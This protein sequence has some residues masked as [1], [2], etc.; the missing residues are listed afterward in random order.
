MPS[1]HGQPKREDA[2]GSAAI[3]GGCARIPVLAMLALRNESRMN[4]T[5]QLTGVCQQ[6]GAPIRFAAELVGTTTQCPRCRQQTELFLAPVEEESPISRK[7]KIWV[8]IAIVILV[9]GVVGPLAGLKHFKKLAAGKRA[10]AAAAAGARAA[11]AAAQ[12][13][14]GVSAIALE[15]ASGNAPLE[16]IGTVTNTAG[17]QR[18]GVKLEIDLLDALG[19]RV[20]S[21]TA[22]MDRIETG[23]QWEFR[24]P[25]SE[26]KAVSARL[27]SIKEGQ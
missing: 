19:R 27:A 7:R 8:I 2:P 11:G 3:A 21:A 17:R 26:R 1:G 22:Y 6:C 23:A 4:R 10:Q 9:V 12:A 20:G 25:V 18:F 24:A 14:F 16:A 13:G 5:K 15:N